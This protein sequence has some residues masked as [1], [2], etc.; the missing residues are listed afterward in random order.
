[1]TYI[2]KESVFTYYIVVCSAV[3]MSP[4]SIV[5]VTLFRMPLQPLRQ[6]PWKCVV[7]IF[8]NIY[9][10]GLI[11]AL[12]LL[13]QECMWLYIH[14]IW[15]KSF[16]AFGVIIHLH[17]IQWMVFDMHGIDVWGRKEIVILIEKIAGI[18][19]HWQRWTGCLWYFGLYFFWIWMRVWL[20]D[21]WNFFGW[22]R[23]VKPVLYDMMSFNINGIYG[24]KSQPT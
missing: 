1:M 17:F 12:V 20:E 4:I 14:F 24:L 2:H 22:I 8:R 3:A 21:F 5:N 15:Q 19:E 9:E 11:P 18:G 6:F 23:K 13:A 16:L 7:Y 10:K